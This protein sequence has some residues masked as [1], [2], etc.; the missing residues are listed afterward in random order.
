VKL[1]VTTDGEGEIRKVAVMEG[2][3]EGSSFLKII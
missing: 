2:G 1:W 3:W